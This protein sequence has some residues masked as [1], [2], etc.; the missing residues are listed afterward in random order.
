MVCVYKIVETET[1]LIL[2]LEDVT[3]VAKL[4]KFV[5]M[6]RNLTAKNV[7]LVI[8]LM[9]LVPRAIF[10]MTY[11]LIVM[12]ENLLNVIHVCLVSSMM[13]L[14]LAW[15]FVQIEHLVTL[16]A[17]CAMTALEDAQPVKLHNYVRRAMIL[18]N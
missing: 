17:I 12:E 6:V 14:T 15:W 1:L 3:H 8:G 10:A 5:L 16:T 11:A 13:I 9:I 18:I 2:K 7:I 4:V